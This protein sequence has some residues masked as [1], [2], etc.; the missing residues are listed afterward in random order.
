MPDEERCLQY[1]M[2]AV[3]PLDGVT[4]RRAVG[5]WVR[6]CAIYPTHDERAIEARKVLANYG[7]KIAYQYQDGKRQN[8]LAVAFSHKELSRIFTG[9]HWAARAGTSGVWK[10]A[11]E[12]LPGAERARSPLWFSGGNARAMLLPFTTLF[13]PDGDPG[14]AQAESELDAE[15]AKEE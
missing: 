15:L 14:R 5:E 11:M 7:L 1:L 2:T 4:T 12:R 6:R 9:T 10:Q 8:S 3:I 13:P